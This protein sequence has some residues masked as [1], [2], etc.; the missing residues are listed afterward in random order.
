MRAFPNGYRGYPWGHCSRCTWK[1]HNFATWPHPGFWS[2]RHAAFVVQRCSCVR[3]YPRITH[4]QIIQAPPQTT[5]EVLDHYLQFRRG[6]TKPP[7][8]LAAEEARL[9]AQLART[10]DSSGD[11]HDRD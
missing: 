8:T 10:S 3:T 6:T 2:Q 9:R 11:R 7:S 1:R 4:A 5:D